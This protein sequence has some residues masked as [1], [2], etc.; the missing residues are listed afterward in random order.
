MKNIILISGKA[1]S[2]KDTSAKYIKEQLESE[3]YRVVIDRFAKYIKNYLKD[4][5]EW[6]GV[7][8][9]NDIREKLQQLGTE[10]IKEKLN[11][12]SFH[13]RRLSEDFQIVQDDFDYFLVPDLRFPDE[14]YTM[15]AMFGDKVKT[16]RIERPQDFTGGLTKEHLQ[17]KSETALNDFN[18]DA[19][20]FNYGTLSELWGELDMYLNSIIYF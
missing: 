6:D 7:T 8:K 14:V 1:R 4:Y 5:Y 17:H 15:K 16:L 3:G 19:E 2:G 11:Y 10:V 20:V 18:F 9:N 12:T 13:A